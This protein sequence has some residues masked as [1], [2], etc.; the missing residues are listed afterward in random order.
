V[1][2]PTA[3]PRLTAILRKVV[4]LRWWIVAFYALLIPG[5]LM[6]ALRIPKDNALERMVV[7]ANPDVVATREFQRVFPEKPAVLLLIENPDPFAPK[8]LA[9]V[10]ALQSALDRVPSVTSY[11]LLTVWSRLHPGTATRPRAADELRRFAGGTQ[12]FRAQGLC[13]DGFLGIVLTLDV[14]DSVE[15]DAA[16]R[17][18]DRAI[19]D[20]SASPAG[21]AG[22]TS[23]RRVGGPWLDSW[24]ERETGANSVRFFPLFGA[25]VV[26]L[27]LGLY[28][29]WRAMVTV[30]LSLAT[31]VLL[32]VSCGGLLGF[33][34]TIVSALVPLTLMITATASLVYLHSRFVDQ[35][36]DV[37]LE[38][39][40][41]FALANKV[42][43]VSASVF[44]AAV[45]FAALSVSQIRPIRQLGIWTAVGLAFGWLVC[46]TLYPALQ[47]ILGAPT[48]LRRAVAGSW[49]VRVAQVLPRWS[50][51]WR[52]PVLAASTVMALA[53]LAAMLGIPG[54]LAP[55]RLQTDVL[56]YID[57]D[58]PV[59]RDTRAF[60]KKVLGLTSVAVWVTVPPGTVADPAVLGA[61][62]SLT[63]ELQREPVV[64]SVVG[65][66]GVLR[67]R[68]Y[69][70]GLGD[71]LPTD[72]AGL[73]K[74]SDD[75]EQLLLEEAA[76]RQWVDMSTLSSTYL[77]VTSRAGDSDDFAALQAATE[78][79]F[80]RAEAVTPALASCSY[81]IVGSGVLQATIA[82]HL[83]PT[84]TKSFALTFAIIFV[85]F[86][87]V[88]KSGPARLN[89]MVPSLFAILVMFLFMRMAGIPLNVVT[90]LIATT[91][92]GA[93]END[94]IH[95]FF[96]FQEGHNG[97]S[98][99]Q[100]LAHA[101]RVAG[102]AI[103]FATL[104]NAG[105]FL[106][107]T[108]SNLPPMR[109][110]GAITSA[111]FALAML[112][113]FT[114]LPA[115]LWVFFRAQPDEKASEI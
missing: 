14:A 89:A 100:A 77:T 4:S 40:R 47:V 11:S 26:L 19:A 96:H 48:R 78:R 13:G 59:T 18:I 82:A 30:L 68:R 28:R 60:S 66:P 5:A 33:G 42:L 88:F 31:A 64:G 53:G 65:L 97:T 12:F 114:A 50:Y 79:A 80:K 72:P 51:R 37:G 55:M 7:A 104:I 43:A 38:D 87:L 92:L 46:F 32:G 73:A 58:I 103:V 49:M 16:L 3:S 34:F 36:A 52:W 110:F 74:V 9:G 1:S 108:L 112:A 27:T 6:V 54:V 39:H 113:D 70:A 20:V 109:Q 93:T 99:E 85:T 61:L 57:P 17:S 81:R 91:V 71:A 86:L 76:L 67:L 98:T 15:R 44:A 84:L 83:V 22:I 41:V 69:A 24:L 75:L 95:F 101:I 111:A 62:D 35:A 45:G 23:V 102:H 115:A 8:A 106:A 90:I 107:L 25:F 10:A 2:I 56:A 29:S 63:T 94:Q 21:R 105:G